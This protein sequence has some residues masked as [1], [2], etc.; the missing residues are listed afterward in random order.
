M[1]LPGS[2]SILLFLKM[3]CQRCG[4]C[5]IRLGWSIT[6]D[7]NDLTRWIRQN[8]QD[9]LKHI[10][11]DLTDGQQIRGD[12]L[13]EDQVVDVSFVDLW[14]SPGGRKLLRCPFLRKERKKPQYKCL[15]NETKPSECRKWKPW[16]G[17][18]GILYVI[19]PCCKRKK[20]D[21]HSIFE[22]PL[23]KFV[24]KEKK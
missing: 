5:C 13:K 16:E 21:I 22:K 23:V 8:R 7:K 3:K 9:I 18:P 11:I 19:F 14:N 2:S 17:K 10:K 20:P 4:E 6:T 24:K 1:F 15:I 12:E